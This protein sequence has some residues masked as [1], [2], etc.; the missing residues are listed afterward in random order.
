MNDYK[1][2][3]AEQINALTGGS[4][5]NKVD[6]T[7]EEEKPVVPVSEDSTATDEEADFLI[8]K[9]P[10]SNLWDTNARVETPE[11]PKEDTASLD[12]GF[13]SEMG[14][15][16]APVQAFE[17]LEDAQDPV[18]YNA[19][20][21]QKV[22][23][24]VVT[25]PNG[26][27]FE[28][29]SLDRE[30]IMY[31]YLS[32]LRFR[33]IQNRQRT[34]EEI[35]R[36]SRLPN[37]LALRAQAAEDVADLN[38]FGYTEVPKGIRESAIGA[39]GRGFVNTLS[40][41]PF[42]VIN[43]AQLAALGVADS[44]GASETAKAIQGSI[45]DV[46]KVKNDFT[47]HPGYYWQDVEDTFWRKF[48]SGVGSIAASV[49]PAYATS[50]VSLAVNAASKA[51]AKA[52]S[53]AITKRMG[54]EAAKQAG[55]EAIESKAKRVVSLRNYMRNPNFDPNAAKEALALTYT[56]RITNASNY[57]IA[58]SE[59]A[60]AA[61][62]VYED[63]L[64]KTNDIGLSVGRALEA[65][66]LVGTLGAAPTWAHGAFGA[67]Y[68]TAGKMW[69]AALKG[70]KAR[71]RRLLAGDI[72]VAGA[73][74]GF[75]EV[76]QDVAAAGYTNEPID[77]VDEAMTFLLAAL[78]A[79]GTSAFSSR[80][81]PTNAINNATE[82]K[83]N[84]D[85]FVIAFND[86]IKKTL[87]EGASRL[88]GERELAA[89]MEIINDPNYE[90]LARRIVKKGLLE[91]VDKMSNMS[92]ADKKSFKEALTNE[93]LDV[94]AK[95][96]EE[97]DKAINDTY[98]KGVEGLTVA[99]RT[100]LKSILHGVARYAILTRQISTPMELLNGKGPQPISLMGIT[101]GGADSYTDG[102]NVNIATEGNT[103]MRPYNAG[104]AVV[105]PNADEAM[106]TSAK[107]NNQI[108]KSA[109]RGMTQGSVDILHEIL[110]HMFA[111]DTV[112]SS[113][114]PEFL[115]RYTEL[116]QE[117]ISEVFPNTNIEN[118]TAEELDEYR[119][120]AMAN[121]TKIAEMLGFE[122]DTAKLFSF[123]EQ[124]ALA[125][126]A[127]FGKIKEYVQT[128]RTLL[129][130]NSEGIRGLIGIYEGDL[131]AA[132][133][134]YAE[135][136]E[137][138]LLTPED[139]K[140]L[141]RVF[142]TGLADADAKIDLMSIIGDS[143]TYKMLSE[144]MKERFNAAVAQDKKDAQDAQVKLKKSVETVKKNIKDSPNAPVNEET[145][146]V[147]EEQNKKLGKTTNDAEARARVEMQIEELNRKIAEVES[148][149]EERSMES[150]D[151]WKAA[152]DNEVEQ[153]KRQRDE[154]MGL[155]NTDLSEEDKAATE[156]QIEEIEYKILEIQDSIKER[157]L[158]STDEWKAEVDKEVAQ[159]TQQRDALQ[160]LLDS[161]LELVNNQR[162]FDK[163]TGKYFYLTK[164]PMVAPNKDAI[165]EVKHAKGEGEVGS[166]DT[167]T[168]RASQLAT[169]GLTKDELDGLA[170]FARR[171]I[172]RLY[173]D[174]FDPL[175][176][177]IDG[178]VED[179]N[180]PIMP[181]R[182]KDEKGRTSG[183]VFKF[184]GDI[185][186]GGS[187][188]SLNSRTAHTSKTGALSSN[189]A[190]Y[191][192]AKRAAKA[193]NKRYAVREI[194][195]GLNELMKGIELPKDAKIKDAFSV[196][197]MTAKEKLVS[198]ANKLQDYE[199]QYQA[200]T[201][202]IISDN[203]EYREL[204]EELSDV[205]AETELD[206]SVVIGGGTSQSR[207][208]QIEEVG[209][210]YEKFYEDVKNELSGNKVYDVETKKTRKGTI[211][212]AKARIKNNLNLT[213]EAVAEL[214]AL[215]DTVDII[216]FAEAHSNEYK[217]IGNLRKPSLKR[218]NDQ[219][220]GELLYSGTKKERKGT[221]EEAKVLIK[222]S[223][224]LSEEDVTK[225]DAL[226][227]KKSINEFIKT[228]K[229]KYIG[230]KIA[231]I[232]SVVARQL[233]TLVYTE[234]DRLA[235]E[236]NAKQFE[237]EIWDNEVPL[238][239]KQK[240]QRAAGNKIWA[241]Q[242]AEEH[243]SAVS[244]F[245]ATRPEPITDKDR[246]AQDKLASVPFGRIDE[247]FSKNGFKEYT[248]LTNY[249]TQIG[250][251]DLKAT[252]EETHDVEDSAGLSVEG[253]DPEYYGFDGYDRLQAAFDLFE[254][255][256]VTF[257]TNSYLNKPRSGKLK[258][259]EFFTKS[260]FLRDYADMANTAVKAIV[261][262]KSV[263]T[264]QDKLTYVRAVLDAYAEGSKAY[265]MY[266]EEYAKNRRVRTSQAGNLLLND[267][268]YEA[269]ASEAS[270]VNDYDIT[271]MPLFE[272][273]NKSMFEGYGDEPLRMF[274]TY[275][276]N[277]LHIGTVIRFPYG[278]T[279][280]MGMI[281]ETSLIP[282]RRVG[283]GKA[284]DRLYLIREAH[285]DTKGQISY[286]EL[287]I[288]MSDFV[289]MFNE[290]KAVMVSDVRFDSESRNVFNEAFDKKLA[291]KN[292]TIKLHDAQ[293]A[294]LLANERRALA[295]PG[296]NP[297]KLLERA[298][299]SGKWQSKRR[300]SV[301]EA[302]S[303]L[304]ADILKQLTA[305]AD[306]EISKDMASDLEF[307]NPEMYNAILTSQKL[308][309]FP[310]QVGTPDRPFTADDLH[311]IYEAKVF[312]DNLAKQTVS[313]FAE[314]P[315]MGTRNYGAFMDD[316]T[317]KAHESRS[318][319][320]IH[321]IPLLLGS[322]TGPDKV[323]NM[324]FGENPLSLSMNES[325]QIMTQQ[326]ERATEQLQ[327][328][329]A[330]SLQKYA[331][332]NGKKTSA[333]FNE[334]F[335]GRLTNSKVKAE[336]QNGKT[337]DITHGEIQT[338][339]AAK[340]VET[341]TIGKEYKYKQSAIDGGNNVYT[342]LKDTMYKNADQ[343]I[344]QLTPAEK[345]V[346]ET[347]LDFLT[348]Y[349]KSQGKR[350]VLSF[351]SYAKTVQKGWNLRQQYF[352]RATKAEMTD[353][354]S[355]LVVGDLFDTMNGD[356]KAD[357][358]HNSGV[359]KNLTTM[360]NMLLFGLKYSNAE[361]GLSGFE[362]FLKDFNLRSDS[363]DDQQTF[364][365]LLNSSNALREA[366]QETLG[367]Y[368]F[369]RFMK[370]LDQDEMKPETAFK[371]LPTWM[372]KLVERTT[373]ASMSSALAFKPKN[374]L[375][376][377]VGAWQRLAPLAENGA[378][379]HTTD[380]LDAMAHAKTAIKEAKDNTFISQRFS[381]NAL[382]EEYQKVTDV[383]SVETTL[384]EL[385]IWAKN[386]QKSGFVTMSEIVGK[387]DDLAKK[388]T[389]ISVGYGTSGADFLAMALAW[390]KLRPTL[391]ARALE[392]TNANIKAG[393]GK[394]L[395]TAEKLFMNHVLR[396][397]SSSNFMTR[398]S[399]QNWALRNHL[400]ALT[401]FLNDSLQSY[402]AIGEA[403]Y[404]YHNAK[405]DAEKRYLRKIITSNIAS[406]VFYMASQIGAFS[407]AYGLL[408][409]DDGLTDAEQEYLWGALWREFIGQI[410]SMTPYDSATRPILEALFLN[411]KRS[412]VNI[413][414][415]S[416]QDLASAIHDFDVAKMFATSGD[417]LGFAG[418]RRMVEV[419]DAMVDAYS[420][421][422]MSYKI[423]GEVLFGASKN[424]AM[425]KQGLR[426]N[427]K[428]KIVEKK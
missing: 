47:A 382:G 296:D 42:N 3:V 192:M 197:P 182:Q 302:I 107:I 357:A 367:T 370:R 178:I 404:M 168:Y 391:E 204:L 268:G 166:G 246:S 251:A 6:A 135:T 320:F 27:A 220:S 99:Q 69:K 419:V 161:G 59:A 428:G 383:N 361:E 260:E 110:G 424:T 94:S 97:F 185:N 271:N 152:V 363:E 146:A 46:E 369:E 133:K 346:V 423:A 221:I 410:S 120:Y 191:I 354:S 286:S 82:F 12:A 190:Y 324:V 248:P 351:G 158:G 4:L 312:A 364:Q 193:D 245:L 205:L 147:L 109:T 216:E 244:E 425:K 393:N 266:T 128:L 39:A 141:S 137:L 206:T 48:G 417:L 138:G 10:S 342:R 55:K 181:F 374:A 229:N 360:K 277:H 252:F 234:L 376:N 275:N 19:R 344:E 280:R 96:F 64:S 316:L 359:K 108:K 130:E 81:A 222:E 422:D 381:R 253:V 365:R 51:G 313:E 160:K 202:D 136:G 22:T 17:P 116:L 187:K 373:R 372:G 54:K 217:Y 284:M 20:R 353:M 321:K 378:K 118:A 11:E 333:S 243:A 165:K 282:G 210:W 290:G 53:K 314:S 124:M 247:L 44:V 30:K 77:P 332:D 129:Q 345:T 177:A 164:R 111:S 388:M 409:T 85:A 225:L 114:L 101:T 239:S 273:M 420:N 341:K 403:W 200:F 402:S 103:H 398:S 416:L 73:L 375:L 13:A 212:G 223:F 208:E 45:E 176:N 92:D 25:M 76:G 327:A 142:E 18:S 227:D 267:E 254:V 61:Y 95:A 384:A 213:K 257:D 371:L 293:E 400:G 300:Y 281:V 224:D 301:A 117:A 352:A 328:A 66:S 329:I 24:Y 315:F 262:D 175:L 28:T 65:G 8:P 86:H 26:D 36:D 230:K 392:Q 157:N 90:K 317:I 218:I 201:G 389:K 75:S 426:E 274:P 325:A 2:P 350:F 134:N 232:P 207:Q 238:T 385:S 326:S 250:F 264:P 411:E 340:L 297:E 427:S 395:V 356:F 335:R 38:Y 14:S 93:E 394:G 40:N 418:S 102:L 37:G 401:A 151:E 83:K 21:F 258:Q 113:S 171:E 405:T 123:F 203:K 318:T 173:P 379:W 226:T 60:D 336:L 209:D 184:Y 309:D 214:D 71:L 265:D 169:T 421:D 198:I 50:G 299:T 183:Y 167:E 140:A 407:A 29:D 348:S 170:N 104:K 88:I 31:D 119:A 387:L 242:S 287:A 259:K 237:P 241:A 272:G 334:Y 414:T 406:Q 189:V 362:R 43:L 89:F 155:L 396:T 343:L 139:L 349:S 91:N 68:D 323:W 358:I 279:P 5:A 148:S 215:T 249:K 368:G 304:M 52:V 308:L 115:V 413:T 153:L 195:D 156:Q 122:G 292:K 125:D 255:P 294:M 84:L 163:K 194:N 399:L 56:N 377:F 291:E 9:R 240:R 415:K 132:I 270:A 131:P 121:S 126:A 355:L 74:E 307:E 311:D 412:G 100:I 408:G 58:A 23:P 174:V 33:K 149:V 310:Y 72:A 35:T 63:A 144:R 196:A 256:Q 337:V 366:V 233:T 283:E 16:A 289:E 49:I 386:K 162:T 180:Q 105:D 303:P 263:L 269:Y 397:I 106:Q 319:K 199:N 15:I 70:D 285:V 98:L 41:A 145:L 338:L 305:E 87:P 306:Q 79:G 322:M 380:L 278:V 34:W 150:T 143:D 62:R 159:L 347:M 32:Q 1:N 112:S 179:E 78:M 188:I 231:N 276:T 127:N 330:A 219:L 295:K 339:Y 261:G 390:Y 57:F 172:E 67:M 331:K 288:P 228:N 186:L 211:D 298:E 236:E 80:N 7:K 235:K 154:Y